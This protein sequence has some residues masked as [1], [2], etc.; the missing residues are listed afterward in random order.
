MLIIVSF[1][2]QLF[3]PIIDGIVIW[4]RGWRIWCDS[5]RRQQVA[6]SCALILIVVLILWSWRKNDC[7]RVSVIVKEELQVGK[8]V[9]AEEKNATGH[10]VGSLAV[11]NHNLFIE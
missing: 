9:R 10:G 3:F 11:A 8:Q 1:I 5:S 7:I 6:S 4:G 2:W